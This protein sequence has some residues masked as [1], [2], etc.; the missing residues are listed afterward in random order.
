MRCRCADVIAAAAPRCHFRRFTMI[1]TGEWSRRFLRHISL[2]LPLRHAICRCRDAAS[3]Y[4]V[5]LL[6]SAYARR[7]CAT[8]RHDYAAA[9]YFAMLERY[10][11]SPL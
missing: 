4:S 5:Q 3:E 6:N 2:P 7:R 9:F 10:Y 1:R 11:F 8:R